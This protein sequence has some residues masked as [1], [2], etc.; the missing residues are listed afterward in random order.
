M[1]SCLFRQEN[2]HTIQTYH[3][4]PSLQATVVG[5]HDVPLART[6][7]VV[8]TVQPVLSAGPGMPVANATAM[9]VQPGTCQAAQP[10]AV[11]QERATPI[12]G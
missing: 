4:S 5:Q 3:L 1:A 2:G 8:A 6:T 11:V 12:E 10:Y 9:A 7:P